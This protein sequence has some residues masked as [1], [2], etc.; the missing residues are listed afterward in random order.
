MSDHDPE[1]ALD[2]LYAAARSGDRAALGALIAEDAYVLTDAADGE[3]RGRVQIARA[4]IDSFHAGVPDGESPQI[5]QH[6][7]SISASGSGRTAWAF[8]HVVLEPSAGG[9]G[10]ALPLRFTLL[11]TRAD[12]W[13]LAAGHWSTPISNAASHALIEQGKLPM[14][15][16]LSEHIAADAAPF[17]VTLG[18]ALENPE[19]I[20]SLY[21]TG[22]DV[23]AIGS[24]AEEVL[25]GP[26]IKS[27]W[28]EFIGYGPRLAWR[29]GQV[30]ALLE[31]DVGWLASHI[32]ISFDRTTPYR[33]FYIWRREADR[34]RVAVSHDSLPTR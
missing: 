12:S 34:W 17:V 28:E 2:E 16:P 29:G 1:H 18:E 32:D 31:P 3:R 5:K 20:P 19:S 7:R 27:A 9:D 22:G 23:R 4:L 24:A 8:E 30:A 13:Q 26:Q 10:I 33:F 6:G 11:L 15:V 25:V 14:A 21:S